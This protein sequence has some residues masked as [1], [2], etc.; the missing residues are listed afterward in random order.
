M[1]QNKLKSENFWL[2]AGLTLAIM[3]W[4]SSMAVINRSVIEER[5]KLNDSVTYL[6]AQLDSTQDELFNEKVE[7]GR[8]EL[9]RDQ[10]FSK[11]PNLQNEYNQY[12]EHET[13]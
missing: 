12:Y 6:K 13:E 2:R 3:V 10:F 1:E 11:H 8:H 9:T 5:Q 4:L 7:T